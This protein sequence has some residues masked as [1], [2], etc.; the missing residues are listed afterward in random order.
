MFKR[1]KQAWSNGDCFAIPLGE[2][3]FSIGQVIS[4]EP[5]AL[6]S[7]LCCFFLLRYREPAQDFDL[8]SLSDKLI[9]IQ[10]VTRD[11]LDAGQWRVIATGS[12]TPI[13]SSMGLDHLRKTGFV[14]IKV[15][16]SGIANKLM[17]SCFGLYPWDGFAEPGYLDKLLISKAMR[18][19]SVVMRG[20]TKP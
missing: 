8:A 5:D 19:E 16:G 9:A 12:P 18:P 10:F 4:Y 7:V 14:G 20:T 17:E 11:L 6:N 3:T 15:V 13:P 2:G 1:N